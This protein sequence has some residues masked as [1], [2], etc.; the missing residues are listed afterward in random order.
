LDMINKDFSEYPEHRVEFFQ[1]SEIH[2]SQLFPC[3]F[4]AGQQAIQ[5]CHR[6]LSLGKQAR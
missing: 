3:T 2:Q 5:V 1:T 6:C 4:E